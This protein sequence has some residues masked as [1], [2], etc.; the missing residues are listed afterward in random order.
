VPI[1]RPEPETCS[2]PTSLPAMCIF[3]PANLL[4]SV[5]EPAAVHE[6]LIQDFG[7]SSPRCN[8]ITVTLNFI[9]NLEI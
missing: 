2:L 3:G 5:H 9:R 4:K 8:Q 7:A 6:K 1:Q